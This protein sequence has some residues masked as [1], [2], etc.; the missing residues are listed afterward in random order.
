MSLKGADRESLLRELTADLNRGDEQ[1]LDRLYRYG[2]KGAV[3][4]TTPASSR[5]M[6]TCGSLGIGTAEWPILRRALRLLNS[7]RRPYANAIRALQVSPYA[8]GTLIA[9][10]SIRINQDSQ[11]EVQKMVEEIAER[12]GLTFLSDIW[13]GGKDRE[14]GASKIIRGMNETLRRLKGKEDDATLTDAMV[15]K[16]LNIV[17]STREGRRRSSQNQPKE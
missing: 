11:S 8:F 4:V 12:V 6:L 16:G 2:L 3:I 14:A 1:I 10:G 7:A 13:V 5:S 9:D 17:I 15:A